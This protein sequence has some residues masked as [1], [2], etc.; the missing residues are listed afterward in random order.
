VTL[1][2]GDQ[3]VGD[4]IVDEIG[5]DS[6]L[7]NHP[8]VYWYPDN[9]SLAAMFPDDWYGDPSLDGP[10]Y[11][12]TAGWDGN[13]DPKIVPVA[14]YGMNA[15]R[16]GSQYTGEIDDYATIQSWNKFVSTGSPVKPSAAVA[17]GAAQIS[18]AY[19]RFMLMVEEDVADGMT[20]S[21]MKLSGM[22]H[23]TSNFCIFWYAP[24]SGGRVQL[25]RYM[26]SATFGDELGSTSG[27]MDVA[28]YLY[29]GQVHAL[30]MFIK[31]NSNA[32]TADGELRMWLDDVLIFERTG[33]KWFDSAPDSGLEYIHDVRGQI[34]HGGTGLAPSTQIHH[35]QFGFCLASR[36]IGAANGGV[37][38]A[39][40]GPG[41]AVQIST[42]TPDVGTPPS[43]TYAEFYSGTFG[44]YGAGGF[45][46]DYSEH[47][48]YC[49]GPAGG[50]TVGTLNNPGVLAFNFTTAEWEAR[51]PAVGG[52]TYYDDF[53]MGIQGTD[54]TNGFPL[55]EALDSGTG[56]TSGVPVPG[57]PYHNNIVL[58]ASM[59]G[60][61]MGSI[62]TATRSACCIESRFSSAY[63]RLD[64]ASME[65][66]HLGTGR[67][68]GG[69][70]GNMSNG[71]SVLDVGRGRILH[72]NGDEGSQD[73][74]YL[75]TTD[76]NPATAVKY[77]STISG[78]VPTG[79]TFGAMF[80]YEGYI[81]R[82]GT[83]G[84]PQADAGHR[85]KLF[86]FDQDDPESSDAGWLELN[87]TDNTGNST[88]GKEN[89]NCV[90]QWVE[91]KGMFYK[92]PR[93]GGTTL[94]TLTPPSLANIKTGAWTLGTKTI[95]SVPSC[96]FVTS[97]SELIWHAFF[98]IEA[99]DCFGWIPGE[100]ARTGEVYLIGVPD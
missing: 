31:M 94:W 60:G 66:T 19:L 13:G 63:H 71:S 42:N 76:S 9:D 6:E 22:N 49:I 53:Y 92:L 24:P 1:F 36:R 52:F 23:F 57:H 2:R 34:Y 3:S 35:R 8:D 97:G 99:L 27:Q 65:Y 58:P 90:W 56:L 25:Y 84:T 93:G 83:N 80:M 75:D 73:I 86:L 4:L 41:E 78:F 5:N 44:A 70:A 55:F 67:N 37:P 18:Q 100:D 74:E 29:L 14:E 12:Y 16:W 11:K 89:L 72:R 40:P 47:G 69:G 39:L 68:V 7:A 50:E 43:R 30:E 54:Q 17:I 96:G 15:V 59:G 79:S 85:S 33:F 95:D 88:L 48:A 61:S 98:Y 45:N 32:S 77:T 91:S 82:I 87:Y 20:E 64:I 28:S 38:Y 10:E 46:P 26:R 51:Q 21:G 62:I 81:I